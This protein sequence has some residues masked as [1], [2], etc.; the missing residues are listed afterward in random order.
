M[1]TYLGLISLSENIHYPASIENRSVLDI[2]HYGT[3]TTYLQFNNAPFSNRTLLM[4]TP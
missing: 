4:G 3:C 1:F 2:V